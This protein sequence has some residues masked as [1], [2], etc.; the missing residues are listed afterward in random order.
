MEVIDRLRSVT[1][2]Q[3]TASAGVARWGGEEP[4]ELLVM[5]CMHALSDAKASGRD[6]TQPAD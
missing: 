6:R 1:P 2:R 4:A 3:Q 5:R